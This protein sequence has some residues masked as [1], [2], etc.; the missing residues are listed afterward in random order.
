M[1][2]NTASKTRSEGLPPEILFAASEWAKNRA[3]A[4]QKK[5]SE[6][7]EAAMR[8]L[9]RFHPYYEAHDHRVVG[10][11]RLLILWTT[12]RKIQAFSENHPDSP[13]GSLPGRLQYLR[14]AMGLP[15]QNDDFE[16][17]RELELVLRCAILAGR[18]DKDIKFLQ[19]PYEPS[20]DSV[21]A[22]LRSMPE[23]Q[24]YLRDRYPAYTPVRFE[25]LIDEIEV[26]ENLLRDKADRENPAL[27]KS[28]EVEDVRNPV[29]LVPARGGGYTL[30]TGSSRLW[31]AEKT[32]K[33]TVPALLQ[34]Y[35]GWRFFMAQLEENLLRHDFSCFEE[36][37]GY[38]QVIK[39]SKA[40]G[41]KVTQTELAERFDKHESDISASLGLLRIPRKYR[42]SLQHFPIYR[43]KAIVKKDYDDERVEELARELI[44]GK[45]SP[46]VASYRFKTHV[47]AVTIKPVGNAPLTIEER[48]EL[49][50]RALAEARKEKKEASR[51]T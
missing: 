43:L 50:S 29:E 44:S 3:V 32:G 14:Y 8:N 9:W 33:A 24:R 37:D 39:L 15:R 34:L 21:D 12:D 36:A 5:I 46:R 20:R 7:A 13:T 30:C 35:T 2:K 17:L 25:A 45:K 6:F 11:E 26:P 28:V 40:E 41:I 22:V 49:L 48:I 38:D 23:D 10:K 51:K 42:R 31:A 47:G 27:L 4:L 1:A 16:E 18:I 19:S